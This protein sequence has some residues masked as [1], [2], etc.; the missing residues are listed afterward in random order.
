MDGATERRKGEPIAYGDA[1]RPEVLHAARVEEARVLVVVVSD[2]AATRRI[3]AQARR[4]H[5]GIHIVVRTRFVQ[6]MKPL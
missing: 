1:S 4:L 5:A 3:T 6:E 2:P